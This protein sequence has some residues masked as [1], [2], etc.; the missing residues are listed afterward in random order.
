M[1]GQRLLCFLII[2]IL[3]MSVSRSGWA[4]DQPS[5]E[6]PRDN[7]Q[8]RLS[9]APLVKQT[10]PAVVNIYTKRVVRQRSGFRPFFGH[11]FFDDFFGGGLGGVERERVANALGSGVILDQTGLIVTNAHVI[12]D[13]EQINVVLRD[14]REF[15]AEQVFLDERFDL[16]VLKIAAEDEKLP[17]LNFAP[18]DDLEVGDLVLA[19][20]NPFG[21]GQTVTSGIVSA[22]ARTTVG[23]SDYNF[24]IQTDAAIN[25]GNS[26]GALVSMDGY[27]VGINSAIFSRD[28]GSLGIGFA[29]PA[30]LV[31][32]V[33]NAVKSGNDKLVKPWIG[34][35]GQPVTSDIARTLGLPAARG[36]MITHLHPESPAAKAG[37]KTGDVIWKINGQDISDPAALKFYLAMV[38]IDGDVDLEVYRRGKVEKLSFT[39]IRPPEMPPRH[40][41]LLEGRHPL[42]GAMVANINPAVEDELNLVIDQDGVVVTA[43]QS[44]S[45][46]GVQVGDIIYNLNG[47]RIKSVDQLLEMINTPRQGW[48]MQFKR[49]GRILSLSVR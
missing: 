8:V 20:G 21:V 2:I 18:K 12:K 48:D 36:A 39:A 1:P 40:E 19:I 5:R 14:G 9:Y 26:G 34:A 47:T 15:E 7:Q 45:R 42:S 35:K 49:D 43:L 44:R 3:S 23:I 28:G 33:L 37:L 46:I 13:A 16:A 25:P 27:L 31:R 30:E 6:I 4:S 22:L 29:I 32:T 41:T 38:E 11:P 17:V 24:F 10:A